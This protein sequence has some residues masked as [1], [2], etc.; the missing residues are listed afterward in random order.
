MARVVP[1]SKNRDAI[2][3]LL[4]RAKTFHATVTSIHEFDVTALLAALDRRR[5][6]GKPISVVAAVVKATALVVAAHPRLNH[7]LFHGLVRKYEVDFE[8]IACN[9]IMLR[10]ADNGE[11]ILLPLIVDRADQRPIDDIQE[12]IDYHLRTPLHELPQIQGIEKMKKLP[13]VA[14]RAF[15][16]LCRSNHRF[17]RKFFGTYAVSPLIAE[18]QHGV[19]EGRLGIATTAYTNTCAGFFPTAVSSEPR[20]IDGQVVPRKIMSMM[21]A[22]D[23]YLVDGHDAV[24]A[25]RDLAA[26]L[27]EP[28]RLG[29]GVDGQ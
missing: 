26:L 5:A 18:N 7:H 12:V 29:L 16:Y 11:R 19:I 27:A 28:A 8:D 13:R 21:I 24:L 6:A 2:Y 3:D 22:L 10:T 25:T 9:L 1:F 20:V 4:T 17:Y 14:M 23:H 15:S